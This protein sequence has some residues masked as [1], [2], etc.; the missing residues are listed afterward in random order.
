MP[1]MLERLA[2]GRTVSKTLRLLGLLILVGAVVA[3]C[4][5]QGGNTKGPTHPAA[6]TGA[7]D[8]I[9]GVDLNLVLQAGPGANQFTVLVLVQSSVGGRP[10]QGTIV[11]VL[12]TGG[13]LNPAVGSTDVNGVFR[14]ILTCDDG[15]A[16][17]SVTAT[18]EGQQDTQGACGAQTPVTGPPVT[19][20]PPTS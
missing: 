5:G 17:A 18:A 2:T 14:S 8:D 20:P 6:Q 19:T 12:T 7:P 16:P 3:G 13:R 15:G 9:G 1:A 11:T 10:I 4:K